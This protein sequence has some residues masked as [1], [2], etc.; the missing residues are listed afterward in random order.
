MHDGGTKPFGEFI[1]CHLQGSLPRQA[2]E[3]IELNPIIEAD[4]VVGD[5]TNQAEGTGMVKLVEEPNAN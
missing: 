2:A 4:Q 5:H 1:N 3:K